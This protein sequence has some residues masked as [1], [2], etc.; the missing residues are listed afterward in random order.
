MLLLYFVISFSFAV[1]V[2]AEL[3]F[4]QSGMLVPLTAVT[5][6]YFTVSQKWNKAVV[7]FVVACVLLDLSYGRLLPLSTLHVP[8]I[9][10]AGTFWREHGNTM[11]LIT[12]V[13]PGCAI[14][15][16]AFATAS[17]YAAFHGMTSGQSLDFL[18]LS[19]A[20]QSFALGGCAMPVMVVVLNAAMRAFGYMGYFSSNGYAGKGGAD[21]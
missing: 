16:V 7:P 15:V 18:P 14:G 11:S 12:Q 20:V 5:G 4:G 9:L 8:L 6:F 3:C 17:V 2:V 13:L 1:A 19:S 10:V 21:E